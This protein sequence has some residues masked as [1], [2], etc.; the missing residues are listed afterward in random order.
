MKDILEDDCNAN[1]AGCGYQGNFYLICQ[2]HDYG[3]TSFFESKYNTIEK[4]SI[5][6]MWDHSISPFGT[7]RSLH[8]LA[9][10]P[11][12]TVRAELVPE[13][14]L[15]PTHCPQGARFPRKN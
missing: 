12:V 1:H 2:S 8:G 13:H 5:Q 4:P 3:Q 7:A 14:T 10:V 6:P 9:A 11:G 15:I